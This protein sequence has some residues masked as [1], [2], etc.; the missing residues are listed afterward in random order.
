MA[1]GGGS[2][3]GDSLEAEEFKPSSSKS[4]VG[5]KGQQK[6]QIV[7]AVTP[8]K[9]CPHLNSVAP[10]PS[11]GFNVQSPCKTCSDKNENWLCLSCYEVYCGRFI[12]QDMLLHNQN[13]GHCVVLSFADLSVWCYACEAYL[14]NSVLNPILESAHRQKFGEERPGVDLELM[15]A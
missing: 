13:T 4:S 12:H 11:E 5:I 2:P 8:M 15:N 14:D 9:T 3:P 10:V 1:T 7:Y 6:Q